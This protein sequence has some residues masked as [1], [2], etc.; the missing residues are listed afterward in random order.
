MKISTIRYT[1]VLLLLISVLSFTVNAEK[2]ALIVAIGKYPT[3]S[4]WASI[5]SDNDVSLIK[6]SLQKQG[7]K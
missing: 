6:S 2:R 5:S 3:Q 7:F 4:G 1:I